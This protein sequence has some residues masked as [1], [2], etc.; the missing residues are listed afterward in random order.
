[1]TK[2]ASIRDDSRN[3]ART[4]GLKMRASPH[5]VM[6]FRQDTPV[7]E[8]YI[9]RQS[10]QANRDTCELLGYFTRWRTVSEASV[11]FGDYSKKSILHS[12]QNL[13]DHGL[14]ITR[15][16]E[17]YKLEEK[18]GEE[19]LWPTA[20]RYYHFST[21][22]DEPFS[23]PSEIR[24][25]YETYLKGGKQPPIYKSYPGS[26]K[27]KLPKPSGPEEP[28][29]RTLR[30][31]QSTRDLSGKPITLRQLSR[32]LYYTWGRISTFETRE[33]GRLLHK[34]SPSAGARHPVEAYA[35]VNNVAGMRRGIY[36]YSVKDHSLELLKL[37]DFRDKCVALSADQ[38]WTRNASV[39]FIMTAV[40][41]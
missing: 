34:S 32:I 7:L 12:V 11:A 31:R 15:G 36:H 16:S 41:A 8:N 6:H 39:L 25:Y 4:S 27:V 38:A 13:L 30:S 37:G 29:F 9:T 19:W 3:S 10:F 18:F 17:Q 33:F 14:L 21:K 1:M 28:F 23:T 35:V 20:S 24:N 22:L 2:R 26:T 40:V 5:I